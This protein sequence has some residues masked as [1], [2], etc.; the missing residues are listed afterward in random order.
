MPITAPLIEAS[1]LNDNFFELY[2]FFNAAAMNL[3]YK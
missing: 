2:F 3:F 1:T